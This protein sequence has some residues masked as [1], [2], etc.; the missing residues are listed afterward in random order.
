MDK[1]VPIDNDALEVRDGE[2]AKLVAAKVVA[3]ATG[4]TI[5]PNI[6]LAPQVAETPAPAKKG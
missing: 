5:D 1:F 6:P 2:N 3:A 4:Q